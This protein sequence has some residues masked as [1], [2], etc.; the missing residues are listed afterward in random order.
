MVQHIPEA[1][2][3]DIQQNLLQNLLR[4]D[5]KTIVIHAGTNNLIMDTLQNILDKLIKLKSSTE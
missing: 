2:I 5:F 4:E 1:K 3:E